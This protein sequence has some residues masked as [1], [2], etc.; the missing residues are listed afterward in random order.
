MRKRICAAVA[1]ISFLC[2]IG[3]AG[4]SDLNRIS[5]TAMVAQGSLS[6]AA[7]YISMKI[8]GFIE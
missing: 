6:A 4:S 7:L 1:V 2:L 8:G 5:F 3:T